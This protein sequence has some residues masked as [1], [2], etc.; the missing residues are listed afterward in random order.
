MYILI[1]MQK[2]VNGLK[3]D[4]VKS[5]LIPLGASEMIQCKH[6]V[7]VLQPESI[8]YVVV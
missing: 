6:K 1:L 5:S 7:P 2:V 4:S 3:A 8:F